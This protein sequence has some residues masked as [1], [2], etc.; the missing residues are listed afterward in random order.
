MLLKHPDSHIVLR[1]QSGSVS[2]VM[3][4]Q[5]QLRVIL[6]QQPD[7]TLAEYCELLFDATGL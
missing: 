6:E 1:K 2:T 4:C 7:A 3:V 5:D